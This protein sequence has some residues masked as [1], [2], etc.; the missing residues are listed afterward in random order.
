[1][2]PYMGLENIIVLIVSAFFLIIFRATKLNKL[3]EITVCYL[4]LPWKC[5]Q[6]RRVGERRGRPR[7]G[8]VF[9]TVLPLHALS[10]GFRGAPTCGYGNVVFQTIRRAEEEDTMMKV[11]VNMRTVF[12]WCR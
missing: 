1:M 7:A 8:A 4:I 9:Q 3:V 2:G 10:V 12:F 5:I 6:R 11:A